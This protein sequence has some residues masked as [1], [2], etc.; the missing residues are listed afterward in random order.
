MCLDLIVAIT[1]CH[2]L[3]GTKPSNLLCCSSVDRKS[4]K[5]P[6]GKKNQGVGNAVFLSVGSVCEASPSF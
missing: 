2:K 5:D 1:N 4:D 3:S 6:T